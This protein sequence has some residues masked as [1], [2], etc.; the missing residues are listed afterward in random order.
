MKYRPVSH[1]SRSF[2]SRRYTFS[3][4][5]FVFTQ[6]K[7]KNFLIKKMFCIKLWDRKGE[8]D[9]RWIE[10]VVDAQTLLLVSVNTWQVS[11]HFLI[12]LQIIL[13]LHTLDL[14]WL[15]SWFSP[16]VTKAVCCW[17]IFCAFAPSGDTDE[18]AIEYCCGECMIRKSFVVALSFLCW[19]SSLSVSIISSP[20]RRIIL[21][22]A[23]YSSLI[24][25]SLYTPDAWTTIGL[26]D[27]GN[28]EFWKWFVFNI[29]RSLSDLNWSIERWKCV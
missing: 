9:S 14:I 22:D 16:I 27:D 29:P 12:E 5:F 10:W 24:L 20:F 2:S 8:G 23:W 19:Y 18:V 7:F 1:P 17:W 25:I 3:S 4:F 6:M 21:F 13:S 26:V 15:S 11:V 28:R